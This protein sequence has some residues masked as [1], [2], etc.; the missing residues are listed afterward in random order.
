MTDRLILV[1]MMGA[2]KTTVGQLLAQRLGWAYL[3]SDAQVVA[4]TGRTVPELFDEFG[5]AGYRAQESRVLAVALSGTDPVVV[6]AA[7]GV[8]LSESNRGLLVR[9]GTVVWLRADPGVLA[10]RVG[11]GAGRPLLEGDPAAALVEL[12]RVR[13]PLYES[14]AG[15]T[16]DVDQ[17]TPAG[18]ADR[19]LGHPALR[20]AGIAEPGPSA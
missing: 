3:D 9:S 13:R 4:D 10:S 18:V 8:V 11:D 6:S 17:L 14:V 2:G 15:V 1:G 12:E 16:V 19:V 5:E 20:A 7:G